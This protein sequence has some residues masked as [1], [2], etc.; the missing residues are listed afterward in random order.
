MKKKCEYCQQEYETTINGSQGNYQRYCS[1]SCKDKFQYQRNKANGSIRSKKSGYPRK[2]SI[3]LYMEARNSDITVPCHYC[4]TR[5]TPDNFQIDHKIPMSKGGFKT[6]AEIQDPDNLV[7]CC[8]TCN[9]EK[10]HTYDYEEF[11]EMKHG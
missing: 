11:M 10:G 3:T 4:S 7:I 8:E 6:R 2:L 5:L 1:T 9:R